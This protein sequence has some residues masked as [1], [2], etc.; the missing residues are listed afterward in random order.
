VP[1]GG[2]RPAVFFTDS[3]LESVF[4]PN[5]IQLMGDRRTL[6]FSVTGES[7]LAVSAAQGRL[8]KLPI[9]PGGRP[10]RLQS[11]W[12]SRPVDGPDGFAIARSGKVYLALAGASQL[13]VISPAGEELARIPRPGQQT[14]PPFDAPASVAFA[15]RSAL[16]TNQ[17][18]PAGNASHWAVF[19]VYT[20]E[21]GLPLYR[22]RMHAR[23]K[24][25]VRLHLRLVYE[26]GRRCA[27]GRILAKVRTDRPKRVRQVTFRFDARRVAVDRRLPF[28]A[29]VYR[30]RP[31]RSRGHRVAARVVLTGGAR[32]V[33]AR[34]VR[35]CRR[36]R[37]VR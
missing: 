20:G 17:S 18:F 15:G 30:P 19:D 2:G 22:P 35:T 23:T 13:V 14:D 25:P 26:R 33:L 16:V 8:F 4:G 27:V 21:R 10:G 12:Q 9:L 29:I 31:G 37:R 7:P 5:G 11:F 3:R 24:S 36:V 1:R 28:A 34:Q 6:M 32:R